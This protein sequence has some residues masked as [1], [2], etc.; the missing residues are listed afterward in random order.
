MDHRFNRPSSPGSRRIAQPFRSSTGTLIYPASY[1]PYYAPVRSSTEFVPGPRTSVERVSGPRIIRTHKDEHAALRQA[2]DDYHIPPRRTTLEPHSSTIRKPLT[3]VTTSSPNRHRPLISSAAEKPSTTL[4]KFRVRDDEPYLVQPASSSSRREHQRN[5]SADSRDIDRLMTTGGKERDRSERGGYRSS[6]LGGGRTIY[7]LDRPLVKV[8]QENDRDYGYEYTDR[9]EQMYRDT[10]PRPRQRRESLSAR[11]ER[12]ISMSEFDRYLPKATSSSRDGPPVTTRGFGKIDRTESLRRDYQDREPDPRDSVTSRNRDDTDSLQR[13]RS[14]RAPVVLQQDPDDGYSSYRED[15][16]DPHRRHRHKSRRDES[17]DRE[18]DRGLG[19]RLPR[20]DESRREVEDKPR[21]HHESSHRRDRDDLEDRDRRPRDDHHGE[22]QGKLGDELALGAAGV[23]AAGLV[24]E[25]FKHRR[26]RDQDRDALERDAN[27][28]RERKHDPDRDRQVS[29]Q[30]PSESS[31]PSMTNSDEERRERRRRRRREKEAKAEEEAARGRVAEP[32]RQED[33]T[34]RPGSYER[35]ARPPPETIRESDEPRRRPHHRKHREHTKDED[36]DDDEDSSDELGRA[37][38]EP[39]H[40]VVR[41]VS[42]SREKEPE[43][44]PKGILRQPREKFP[45]DPAPI[46]EGVAPLKDAGKKGVPPNARW[47][48]IDRKLVN[49]EALD[50]GNERYE[51]RTDYVIVLRVLTR[52]EI[53]Q[54]ATRTQEIRE[55][56]G[57]LYF[58][59]RR[60]RSRLTL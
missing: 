35:D 16:S 55:A 52:E 21:R 34:F 60:R 45:E 38:R 49:P 57:L 14:T 44:K 48:K 56:R 26:D 4:T 29:V 1:D 30:L 59:W 58:F 7:N 27:V 11:P 23:A 36:S 22:K 50:Q 33:D 3:V 51:E 13:R 46:R 6:G 17:V 37:P 8:P 5:Y 42:P 41:V 40:T 2:H 28:P 15:R 39:R 54:Y 10:A 25:G 20:E 53:E 18:N 9:K 24:A 12:P 43:P 47:T 32:G 31:I 19:I